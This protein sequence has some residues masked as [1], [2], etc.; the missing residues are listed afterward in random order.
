MDGTKAP[1][2]SSTLEGIMN[3]APEL[4]I[5]RK[6]IAKIAIRFPSLTMIEEPTVPVELS[7]RLPV[8]PGLNYEV[9]LALQNNDELHFSVG[10]F[11]LEWFPC[12][13][14]SRVK[15]YISA[16]TGFLSS[17][18]RVL[19]HYRGKHCVKAELQ[20]PSGGDWKTVGTWSNLLSFLPLRS[21]LREV[22]NTQP[23]IPPDL[24]QQAAP[25]R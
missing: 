9:W 6:A 3:T 12:T 1:P 10:N 7:I 2:V 21:S 19:E 18:Y 16:V 20:A 5:A 23:I 17:Q 14:S 24:P 11:W 25:D 22:S 8:Q 13:E 15:E 4:I